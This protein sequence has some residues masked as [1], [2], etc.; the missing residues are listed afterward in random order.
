MFQTKK[1]HFKRE[2]FEYCNR[3]RID[4]ID[5]EASSSDEEIPQISETYTSP[6]EIPEEYR[7][8]R[9][10]VNNIKARK[11]PDGTAAALAI[12]NDCDLSAEFSQTAIRN[13]KALEVLVN[14]LE[15]ATNDFSCKKGAVM[16]LC[17]ISSNKVIRKDLT[18]MGI[19]PVLVKMLVDPAQDLQIYASTIIANIANLKR[20]SKKVRLCGGIPILVNLLHISRET[21]MTPYDK[22]NTDS[23]EKYN[24]AK[25][26]AQALASLSQS[27]KN[28]ECIQKAGIVTL[29]KN[30]LNSVHEDI[31][32]YSMGI[33]QNCGT[34]PQFQLAIQT[35]DMIG[36]IVRSLSSENDELKKLCA[37][38]VFK[39]AED[40]VSRDVIRK[41]GGLDPLI[42]L[43]KSQTTLE[44]EDL[45]AAVT[46]A[47]WKCAISVKNVQRF[48]QLG[49]IP[50]LVILL[51]REEGD[52]EKHESILTNV[53]GALAECAKLE[54]NRTLIQRCEGIAPIIGLINYHS[55]YSLLANIAQ[56][57]GECA[58]DLSCMAEMEKH[59]AVR[60]IWSLLKNPSTKVQASA[61]WALVPCIQNA[62]ESGEMVRS[63]VGG[64]E[65]LLK[66]LQSNDNNVIGCTCAALSKVAL[67]RENLSIVTELGVIPSLVKLV[68][69]DDE[70]IKQN[71]SLAIANCCKLKSNCFEFGKL[72]AL[73]HII[74][75][76]ESP[77]KAILRATTFALCNLSTDPINCMTFHQSGVV[78][79]F[80]LEAISSE[81]Q[82]IQ[83]A[84]AGCLSNIRKLALA[85]DKVKYRGETVVEIH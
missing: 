50:V 76:I 49:T 44:N 71:I 6:D 17:K 26:A 43:L 12:L 2:Y 10:L 7:Q 67:D 40:R 32:I 81:D 74:K 75:Y 41:Y 33:I 28:K 52:E 48:D 70:F 37:L 27:N 15:A 69:T 78:V 51:N 5:S 19:I 20:S 57:L 68:Q 72:G 84:A 47:I 14:L 82:E 23:K 21:L 42:R 73:P 36:D 16:I 29:L 9:N 64:I 61:A 8:F 4:V 66:L 59:D 58:H 13:L 63:F 30:L 65:L 1:E 55:N 53:V 22:L 18:N 3:I 11:F 85:A 25:C 62:T 38:A 34:L 83:E 60:L 77:N 56:V 46:G 54:H 45:L 39:H 80:L 24:V 79:P 31:I 35:M